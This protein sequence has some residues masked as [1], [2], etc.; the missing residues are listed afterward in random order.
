MKIFVDTS[1]FYALADESDRYHKAARN[2]YESLIPDAQL[3]ASDYVLVEC[4][5]LARSRLGRKAALQLWDGL[6][7]GI[8]QLIKVE[9]QDLSQARELL[10]RYADQDLSLVD[11]ASFVI[12][13]RQRI[14]SAFT[15]DPHFQIHRFGKGK[16]R[17]FK[18]IPA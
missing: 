6:T 1:A 2:T 16:A 5:F 3:F 8:V 13:E 7:S 14:H 18:V 9:L 15:F 17:R 11:A 12:M 10:E 4:W